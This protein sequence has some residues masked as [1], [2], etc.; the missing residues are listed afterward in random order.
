M[1]LCYFEL[2]ANG[3]E[4]HLLRLINDAQACRLARLITR[5]SGRNTIQRVLPTL[6]ALEQFRYDAGHC[7][8]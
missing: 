2:S 6:D 7:G 3:N 8:R 1:C 5:S 4:L